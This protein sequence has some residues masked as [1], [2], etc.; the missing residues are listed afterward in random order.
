MHLTSPY[1]DPFSGHFQT[2]STWTSLYRPP[3]QTCSIKLGPHCTP[4][5]P[6][7]DMFNRT[8]PTWTSL[9][10]ASPDMFKLFHLGPHCTG[11]P[12]V[13]PPPPTFPDMKHIQL[14]SEQ[15]ATYWNAFLLLSWLN[16]RLCVA[17][18][19]G[20]WGCGGRE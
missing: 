8:C 11:H 6:H 5:L 7:R 14:A 17:W 20:D 19:L 4:P 2:C 16:S 12:S 18:W 13:Q 10:R 15:L 1:R 3:P 9:Y